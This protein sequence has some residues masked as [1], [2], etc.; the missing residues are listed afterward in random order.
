MQW[1]SAIGMGQGQFK[2]LSGL[3]E[4]SYVDRYKDENKQMASERIHVENGFAGLKR[5]SILFDRL[6]LQ[7]FVLYDVIH[8]VCAGLWNFYLAN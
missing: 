8:R 1:R 5:F 6:S 3:F 2:I 4:K 7:D